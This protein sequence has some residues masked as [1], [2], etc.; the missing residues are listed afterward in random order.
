MTNMKLLS[1]ASAALLL[2][3]VIASAHH[4]FRSVFDINQTVE[5]TGTVMEVQWTNP[6]A[7]FFVAVEGEDGEVTTWDFELAS[8]NSLFRRGWS[9]HSLKPGDVVTVTGYRARNAPYVANTNTVTGS[10]GD[11]VF[12][13]LTSPRE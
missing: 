13:Q 5:V 1:Y 12:S 11:R 2:V 7:R 4:N 9:R 8:P 10:D 6:H 3:P